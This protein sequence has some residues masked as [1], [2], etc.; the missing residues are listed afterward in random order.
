MKETARAHLNIELDAALGQR[1]AQGINAKAERSLPEVVG[2][3][4]DPHGARRIVAGG[5]NHCQPLQL[6]G[7]LSIWQS[8]ATDGENHSPQE[9]DLTFRF[10]RSLAGLY[11]RTYHRTHLN[12]PLKLPARGPAMLVCN[13]TSSIDPI[14]LQAYSPRLIRW[15]MASEY[16]VYKPMCWV[17]NGVGVIP[18]ERTGRDLAATR[19]AMRA[20]AAGYVLGVFPEG[21]IEKSDELM[22]FQS[23]VGLLALKTGAPVYPAYLDGTQRNLSMVEACYRPSSISVSF[24]QPVD[25]SDLK[26][27]KPAIIE[28][29]HRIESAVRDLR[30]RSYA[31]RI[32]SAPAG[33]TAAA[34]AR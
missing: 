1:P 3:D 28:A 29:T 6:G 27:S 26:E 16:F 15:M 32:S 2:Y 18:V 14:V 9:S 8:V 10:L 25:L 20:L 11:T 19:A 23:G 17:F 31:A 30:T 4:H 22:P 21:K 13:H 33:R 24:G 12:Q 7:S 34:E 5:H